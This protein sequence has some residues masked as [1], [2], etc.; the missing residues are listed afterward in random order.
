MASEW[1]LGVIEDCMNYRRTGQVTLNFKDGV[2][3]SIDVRDHL[4]PPRDHAS[5]SALRTFLPSAC[6][7]I[8]LDKTV[9]RR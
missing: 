9:R 2:V 1:W 3:A 4:T 6:G 7:V 8:A 5:R